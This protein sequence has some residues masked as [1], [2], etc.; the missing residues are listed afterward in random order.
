LAALAILT[1]V[2]SPAVGT[3]GAGSVDAVASVDAVRS[4]KSTVVDV[5]T[6]VAFYG[7]ASRGV[8]PLSFAWS[9]RDGSSS[10]ERDLTHTY[11]HP[12]TYD[13][14]LVVQDGSGR[15]DLDRVTVRVREPLP[16]VDFPGVDAGPDRTAWED[17]ALGFDGRVTWPGADPSSLVFAWDFGDGTPVVHGA[18]VTHAYGNA[19]S[20]RVG[21]TVTN[22][23]TGAFDVDEAV[24]TV[25]NVDPVADAGAESIAG[26]EDDVMTFDATASIDT[27]SDRVDLAYA[28][29]FGDGQRGA[30]ATVSHSYARGGTYTVGLTV[31]DDN[32]AS[33]ADAVAV[34]VANAPPRA[35]AG[36]IVF[37]AEGDPAHLDGRGSEDTPSDR[38]YLQYAWTADPT[39]PS[40]PGWGPSFTWPD[41]GLH[42]VRLVVTDDDGTTDAA[43]VSIPVANVPPRVGITG[44]WWFQDELLLEGYA[45]DPGADDL[46]FEW[47]VDGQLWYRS[48]FLA[49]GVRPREVFGYALDPPRSVLASEWEVTLTVSDGDGGVGQDSVTIVLARAAGPPRPECAAPPAL[50]PGCTLPPRDAWS[51]DNLAPR[52]DVT[53][54]GPNP[55]ED[56]TAAFEA[57]FVEDPDSASLTYLWEF[58]NGDA[59]A[60]ET[61]LHG[62]RNSGTYT[63]VLTVEDDEGD[64]TSNARLVTV[65]N[66]SPVAAFSPPSST[67][68]D[69]ELTTWG[70]DSSDTPSDSAELVYAWRFSDGSTAVGPQG[71]HAF[72]R[73]G[74]ASIVLTVIDD[75]GASSET[76]AD[77][78]VANVAPVAAA[79]GP[80]S[81]V[82]GHAIP[83][84]AEA[85]LDT[86]SDLPRLTYEWTRDAHPI[87]TGRNPVVA[88]LTE[89]S[90]TFLLR[91]RDDRGADGVASVDV[92]V[93]NAPPWVYAGP[94]LV[95][96][97]DAQS[98][99]FEG[100]AD[101]LAD[102][103][104]LDA[105]W[106]F[107]D[108]G[109]AAGFL[110][111]HSFA[112]SGVYSACLEV[113]DGTEIADDCATV[114]VSL[115]TDGDTLLD[116]AER[117]LGTN[118][119][120]FDTDG[121]GLTDFYE[122]MASHTDPTLSDTDG[123]ALNDWE[124]LFTGEDSF[125]TDPRN[126]DTD[127]DGLSDGAEFT[128]YDLVYPGLTPQS[129]PSARSDHQPGRRAVSVGLVGVAAPGMVRSAVLDVEISHPDVAR[130]TV[131]IGYSTSVPVWGGGGSGNSLDLSIDLL[132]LF[133]REAFETRRTWTLVVVNRMAS[134]GE[135]QLMRISL[136]VQTSPVSAD[137][138]DDGLTDYEETVR[139]R[140]G[141][142]DAWSSDTDN[143]GVGDGTDLAP[144]DRWQLP[145]TADYAAGL[146]RF[147]Q[148][149]NAYAVQG[150]WAGIYT[151]HKGWN[152]A[153]DTCD[154]LS[155]HTA[156]ATR[157]SDT[158][159]ENVRT[160][161]N[162]VLADGGETNVTVT[163]VR[164]RGV[165]S[166]G[167]AEYIY[168]ACDFW[169][170]RQYRIAYS[171]EDIAY[172]MDFV[173]TATMRMPDAT[174]SFFQ[175][176]T[177]EVPIETSKPQSIVVQVS[178]R[179]DADRT[180]AGEGPSTIV[181]GMVYHLHSGSGFS[182]AAPF[183][184]N[185][186]VGTPLGEHGY[187]FHLRVPQEVAMDSNTFSRNGRRMAVLL[188]SPV[189]LAS[190]GTAVAKEALDPSS[191]KIAAIVTDV[192]ESAETLVVRLGLDPYEIRQS[193][194]PDVYSMATGY[195]T[196]GGRTVY[197]YRVGGD[198][199]FDPQATPRAH[200]IFLWGA[201]GEAVRAVEGAIDWNPQGQWVL[202]VQ[203]GFSNTVKLMKIYQK[204]VKVISAVTSA[205]FS[206]VVVR[207]RVLQSSLLDDLWTVAKVW[208]T[209]TLSYRYVIGR[210]HTEIVISE[211]PH[212]EFPWKTMRDVRKIEYATQ[213]EIVD[214]LDQ[215]TLLTGPR[216][217]V[218]KAGLRGATIGAVLVIFGGEAVLAFKDGDI[219]KGTIYAAATATAV[220]G[221]VKHNTILF[222][223]LAGRLG[224][225]GGGMKLA[226]AATIAVGALLAGYELYLWT[227]TDDPIEKLAHLE[228]A[229]AI[230]IDTGISLVPLY[231]A[232]MELTWG[233]GANLGAWAASLFGHPIDSVALK[234]VSSPGSV[235]V[236]FWEY[237]FATTIPSA[238]CEDALSKLLSFL[239]DFAK[240]RNSMNPPQPTILLVP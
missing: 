215:S 59:A 178:I 78:D 165:E 109:T 154:W 202:P 195:Y 97:G 6:P 106:T 136:A 46:L 104:T 11:A 85:S 7:A 117:G 146:V 185:L 187:E 38:P 179:A 151:W 126:V 157:N 26:F 57:A 207:G 100:S 3:D 98:I 101:D 177:L 16:G 192:P 120:A 87:A 76:R 163:E 138:D 127:L 132:S 81:V 130:L 34:Q 115:D 111:T 77:L 114:E 99:V 12:G 122:Y 50:P 118:P 142:S 171:F 4:V 226:T 70:G 204:G 53:D 239:A 168:G 63:V 236:F 144:S 169:R 90:V 160:V 156:D 30:A 19:G 176:S 203:D 49:G 189:W 230:G 166:W 227:Q 51:V 69:A 206:P 232:V 209:G 48:L 128:G 93:E 175:Y 170:P 108:G 161:I 133:G 74:A 66:L 86:P 1:I 182:A 188:L 135:L 213:E 180:T 72:T 147:T 25:R 2:F 123:D 193:L 23:A 228:N 112:A 139:P 141:P 191:V 143:D 201:S 13:V 174:G 31:T 73:D 37:V 183:Y 198:D 235:I 52:V 199:P 36:S 103:A 124:E 225:A 237:I 43:L 60:G 218:L 173:N 158:G 145:W 190:D 210:I 172:D 219:I 234:I 28:W 162:Q 24:A 47:A 208:D 233:L 33:S 231:G 181:P 140:G 61:V 79:L 194:P 214:D 14:A 164:R 137:P 240:Y 41:E 20:Y 88:L 229:A 83:L 65:T 44:I 27:P 134:G 222:E 197:V 105:I 10:A 96:Y 64:R 67:Q 29:D 62:F 91:V 148:K 184:R 107:S 55:P 220:F 89:G 80:V 205:L 75:N 221:I 40:L 167:F 9:F 119:H 155:D 212:P 92:L 39:L 238:I 131:T 94:D 21:V 186:A 149:V 35:D 216:Y 56:L 153:E 84:S 45:F 113:S 32:G 150:A 224:L 217:A 22:P 196:F 116:E 223:N 211:Y 15:M 8:H 58:G 17:E 121:D 95:V 110:V 82:E 125:V 159:V 42:A 200:A 152:G 102:G 71:R 5:G 129:V 68:E 18:S 54:S